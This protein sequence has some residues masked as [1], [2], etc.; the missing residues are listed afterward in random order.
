M[1][2]V[3]V[4]GGAG[5]IGSHLVAALLKKGYA[6]R[7]LDDLSSGR[8]S[9]LEPH[10]EEI[11]FIQGS[12]IDEDALAKAFHR[13][14]ACLHL[15]AIPSV[16]RSIETPAISNRVNVEGAVDVFLAARSAGVR[17]IVFASSSAVYG[18]VSDHAVVETLPRAPIS[19]YG[20][21]KAAGE[22]Y[23]DV[24]SQLYGLDIVS[25]R[26]F[27]VF[28]P[29]QDPRS[30]YA[31]V[32]PIFLS[33]LF[34]QLPPPIH[35]DGQQSRDFTYIDNVVAAN[36]LA[37]EEPS[38]IAGAYNIAC[39]ES[40]SIVDLVA[41]LNERLELS[42][43]PAFQR[44]RTGDIRYSRA[45]I[46]KARAAFGYEPVVSVREGINRTLEWFQQHEFA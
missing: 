21:T 12:I 16:P 33:H 22:M 25:L 30:P 44:S 3:L 10:L 28:G 6:V 38:P 2:R 46:S 11:E 14:D 7:V 36:L 41:M 9:N 34:A 43:A 17:R 26:Y 35:G 20:V 42:V 29:R 8:R 31:A 27:N 18:N 19:P 15:A 13:V 23:A 40:T 5:F 4:T 45:D 32:I 39:G 1:D 37:L 24:F